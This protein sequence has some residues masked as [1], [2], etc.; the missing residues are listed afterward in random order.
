MRSSPPPRPV[1][2]HGYLGFSHIGPVAYFR[3]VERALQRNGVEPLIPRAPAAGSV[4]ERAEAFARQLFRRGEP[5]FKLLAHS[6]G[7]LDARYLITHLDPDRRVKS[8]VTVGT[9]HR[10]TPVASR[11][12]EEGG[13]LPAFIRRI[14]RPGLRELT[15]RVRAAEP[16]PDRE[17]V[18][19]QSYAGSRPMSE[20]AAVLRH[21]GR[22][23]PGEHDGLVPLESARWGSF[24][25]ILRAD[26]FELV[27]WN[28]GVANAAIARPLAHLDFW[29]RT[30]A[31][32]V[33]P[34]QTAT[35][36]RE[37]P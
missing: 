7:G 20:I 36:R 11:L 30:D 18:V 14:G 24:R 12:E 27:G 6:M 2:L 29:L 19:Y 13:L 35:P 15:P 8:L 32:R 22:V 26:H 25:G 21:F 16:I 5:A 34:D 4:A 37:A 33:A 28:L 31:E 1:L 17:D 3:G 10:G 9:P 23:I